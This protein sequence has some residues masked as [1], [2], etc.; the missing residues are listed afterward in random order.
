MKKSLLLLMPEHFIRHVYPVLSEI[1]T[2][3]EI[4]SIQLNEKQ[5]AVSEAIAHAD[6]LIWTGTEITRE[7]LE[8]AS[9]LQLIQK[10]GAGIDGIDLIA[11]RQR[12]IPVANV[13]GGNAVAVAEHFFG[14][15]LVLY[16][17]LCM[18]NASIHAGQWLQ[19]ELIDQGIGELHGKTLGLI[20]FGQIGRAVTTRA[21]AF[22]MKVTY[23][24][25]FQ[26]S[27]KEEQELQ[28]SFA[29]LPVL[30]QQADVVGL[31]LPLTQ[32]TKG[33]FSHEMLCQMKPSAV[34]INVSRGPIVNEA[35]LYQGLMNGNL[36]GAGLDVFE[37][38]PLARYNPLLQMSSV[39]ATPHIAGRTREAMRQISVECAS[40]IQLILQG[41]QPRHLINPET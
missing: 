26:L 23:H 35:A 29:P 13:P 4:T 21:L 24:K 36:A 41:K 7:M 32:N 34:L 30:V 39:I 2:D 27:P 33:L 1:L 19:P 9:H 12:A 8:E 15:L 38:E 3:V 31:T 25:R 37:T 14:L 16:K 18:A 17:K 20:G 11:A 28:V 5:E 6:F 10:W 40:N 22:G